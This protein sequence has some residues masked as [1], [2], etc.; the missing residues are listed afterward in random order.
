[1][2]SC[3]RRFILMG[4]AAVPL[5]GCGFAPVYGPSGA[6]G[7][8]QNAV[9]VDDPGDR[10]AYLLTREVEDRLGRPG[11]A[12][13]GLSVALD[14]SEEAAAIASTNVT[15]RYNLIGRAT[16]ALRD[17]DSGAV[18]TS[19]KVDNFNGY[20]ASGTTVATQAASR[21]A[22]ARLMTMLADQIVARLLASA[23]DLPA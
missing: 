7:R 12:R 2:S 21:D 23:P 1:M 6:G 5:A 22:R 9:L 16:Y 3:N 13:Y 18:L 11:T 20:S 4:L 10:D 15:T 14:I 19:G 8:L 17:L